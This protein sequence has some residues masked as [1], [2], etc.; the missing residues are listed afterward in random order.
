MALRAA[1]SSFC[2][3]LKALSSYT[4]WAIKRQYTSSSGPFS[5][6]ACLRGFFLPPECYQTRGMP[7][8]LSTHCSC[9]IMGM[10]WSWHIPA[11]NS[12]R[13]FGSWAGSRW[14]AILSWL[15]SLL[16]SNHPLDHFEANSLRPFLLRFKVKLRW[17]EECIRGNEFISTF[18]RLLSLHHKSFYFYLFSPLFCA[19]QWRT[20]WKIRSLKKLR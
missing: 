17:I 18:S 14:Y 3:A 10:V 6:L 1:A 9:W 7:T 2:F 11:V 5:F 12:G 19:I 13:N 4:W 20:P 8:F 15:H 16:L